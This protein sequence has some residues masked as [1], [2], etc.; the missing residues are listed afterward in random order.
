MDNKKWFKD[1]KMGLMI[2]WGL[3]SLLAG[4]Y[5]GK[6]LPED[7][8]QI[9]EWIM[10]IMRIPVSEYE[11]LAEAFNPIYFDAEEWVKL[12]KEAGMQYIVVTTKHHE[13]FAMF[14]SEADSYNVVDATPFKRDVIKELADAC[15]K[16][17]MKLGLYYS[18]EL[19]WHEPHGGGYTH[20]QVGIVDT[21]WTNEW[22]F[23]EN[24]KKDFSICFEKKI[25]PQVKELLTNYGEIALIWFDTP[26]VIKPEQSQELY[27]MVKKY[28][29]DCLVNSRIGNDL[30]DYYS[31]GDNCLDDIK[32]DEL[33]E[34]PCTMNHTWGYVSYDNNWKDANKLHETKN[35]LNAS[36]A[37]YLINVGPDHLGRIPVPSIE[38]LKELGKMK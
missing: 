19:D 31:C 16:H 21:I 12:A 11:K 20:E 14:K 33:C 13:G 36:G 3:Y 26:R 38:I 34:C 15:K 18:Q 25:K 5:K 30:G 2:H 23:P 32:E 27:D 22:D 28:Q 10:K 6:R 1:A 17:D 24:D 37:N 9:G 29:P 35:K 8:E 7:R 4:E